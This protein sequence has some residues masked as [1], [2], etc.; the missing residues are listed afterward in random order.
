MKKTTTTS[1][2][3]CLRLNLAYPVIID[4]ARTGKRLFRVTYGMQVR[5]GLTYVEACREFGECV[6][7]ALA[8]AERLDNSGM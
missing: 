5:D 4:Q 3:R 1:L 6:F 8:C 7:H 2:R